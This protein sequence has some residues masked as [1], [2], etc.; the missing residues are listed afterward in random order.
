MPNQGLLFIPDISGFTRF[1]NSIEIEHSRMIIQELLEVIV[2]ANKIGLEI[3]EIEG[4]AVL[5]YKYGDSPDLKEIYNQVETMFRD[6]HR[7]L[8]SYDYR[9]FCQCT[10]CQSAIE[11]SLKVIT[12][13][14]EF[15]D[16]QVQQFKKLIGKDIIVAHQ[17]LKNDIDQHEYWLVTN[18]LT[19][20]VPSS[21]ITHGLKWDR[22]I[23][24][25]ESGDIP[26]YYAQLSP[27]KKDIKPEPTTTL[28]LT[29][30]VKVLSFTREYDTDI[31]TLFHATGTFAYKHRWQ[32]GIKTVEE[33]HH[34]LPRIGM[35]AK[36]VF[37]NGESMVYAS[38]YTFSPEHIEFSETNERD[39]STTYYTLDKLDTMKSKLRIDYYIQKSLT[40]PLVFNLGRKNKKEAEFKK[41][42]S[43]LVGLV[44]EIQLPVEG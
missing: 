7:S 32:E 4:D 13:Y 39:Q 37:E 41:S 43:N 33:L 21:E 2:G 28:D 3:S 34:Y 25:T 26:F 19:D 5:F 6:F 40:G 17:L 11:L 42:L 9:K 29:N 18:N 35:R 12:H 36:C 23:K 44:K 27:L 16:Y 22:S 10:A 8:M 15:T 30:K 38:S 14:G 1:V 20:G 24:Q 31:I